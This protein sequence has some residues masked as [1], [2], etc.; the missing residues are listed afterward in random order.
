MVGHMNHVKSEHELDHSLKEICKAL[1]FILLFL[2]ISSPRIVIYSSDIRQVEGGPGIIRSRH[3]LA[4]PDS[5]SL[6]FFLFF[7]F[8][9]SVA[10]LQN[11]S[12]YHHSLSRDPFLSVEPGVFPPSPF[13]DRVIWRQRKKQHSCL[14]ATLWSSMDF[15]NRKN[16]FKST[17]V[18][19]Q[20]K[21]G[22]ANPRKL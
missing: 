16:M 4:N 20:R 22:T 18:C 13:K 9:F 2:R 1:C 17:K 10:G 3:P 11:N 8:L 12:S 19:L 7:L 14:Q 21:T 5:I 15:L 6:S